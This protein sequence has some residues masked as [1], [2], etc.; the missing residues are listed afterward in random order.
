MD[1]Y[2]YAY[3]NAVLDENP[4]VAKLVLAADAYRAAT[5][6]VPVGAPDIASRVSLEAQPDDAI[7]NLSEG[8]DADDVLV[9]RFFC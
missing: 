2:T 4:T 1:T 3:L 8:L 6:P 7:P 5:G 9:V